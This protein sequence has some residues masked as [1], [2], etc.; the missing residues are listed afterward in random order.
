M[1]HAL[2]FFKDKGKVEIFET[3]SSLPTK[4]H[5]KPIFFKLI[6]SHDSRL[7]HQTHKSNERD[8]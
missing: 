7:F 4:K 1:L 8:K 3:K 5:H 6:L 2:F